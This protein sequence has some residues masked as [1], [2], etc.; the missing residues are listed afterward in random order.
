[1]ISRTG[2][3]GQALRGS[4]SARAEAR[5]PGGPAFVVEHGERRVAGGEEHLVHELPDGRVRGRRDGVADHR[6]AG[7][8]LFEEPG[9]LERVAA[10]AREWFLKHLAR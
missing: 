6:V 10:P 5:D 8:A 3:V 7:P 2:T 1:M 9:A 4:S